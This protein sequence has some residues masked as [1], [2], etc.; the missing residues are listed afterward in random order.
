[1]LREST[2]IITPRSSESDIIAPTE[3]NLD[4]YVGN[5]EGKLV[6]GFSGFTE[7]SENIRLEGT[8]LLASCVRESSTKLKKAKLNLANHFVYMAGRRR[9]VTVNPDPDLM[10]AS[11]DQMNFSVITRPDIGARPWNAYS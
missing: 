7:T 2:L 4:A 11:V 9:F 10:K 8:F 1:M 5:I 6:W 3:V